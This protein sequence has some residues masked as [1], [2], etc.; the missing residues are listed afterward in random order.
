[1]LENLRKDKRPPVK[2]ERLDIIDKGPLSNLVYIFETV[3]L[4]QKKEAF[5]E[6]VS[7][8]KQHYCGVDLHADVMYVCVM[9]KAGK[10]VFHHELPTEA[11]D[12]RGRRVI[13]FCA[14]VVELA[15][16]PS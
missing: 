6:Y 11:R 15:D 16:T 8:N 7:I 5:M 14:E 13:S 1:M 4:I 9:T 10:I 3:N 12:G 2:I